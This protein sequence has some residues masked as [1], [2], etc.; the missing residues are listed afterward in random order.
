M[1][2]DAL[3]FD[4][5]LEPEQDLNDAADVI[6]RVQDILLRGETVEY[7]AVQKRLVHN[8]VPDALV[9]TDKRLILY[10]PQLLGRIK[11]EDHSWEELHSPGLEEGLVSSTFRVRTVEDELISLGHLPRVPARRVHALARE[12]EERTRGARRLPSVL[13][14]DAAP[15]APVRVM[16]RKGVKDSPAM[17][18]LRALKRMM[19]EGLISPREFEER[20]T[21]ILDDI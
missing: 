8:P 6:G 4:G 7:V 17:S 9:V 2:D 16:S 10:R 5:F 13:A 14:L 18:R 21:E 1:T 11:F 15:P 12:Y 19:D 20:R 3:D